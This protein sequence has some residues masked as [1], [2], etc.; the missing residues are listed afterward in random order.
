[1]RNITWEGSRGMKD[2]PKDDRRSPLLD[3]VFF[4][5]L[6]QVVLASIVSIRAP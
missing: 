1:M 3:S 2:E 6:S 4:L 5:Q